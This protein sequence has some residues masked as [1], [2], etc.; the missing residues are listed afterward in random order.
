M[1]R[2]KVI[3]L[4]IV[5]T[6][7]TSSVSMLPVEKEKESSA[8]EATKPSEIIEIKPAP[9]KPTETKP[10]ELI[11]V[12][13]TQPSKPSEPSFSG[14]LGPTTTIVESIPF[15]LAPP[16]RQHHYDQRQEGKYNIRAD[17]ENFVIL[18][19]PSSGNSLLDLLRRSTQRPTHHKRTHHTKHHAHKKYYGNAGKGDDSHL[20]KHAS[21][22]DYLRPEPSDLIDSPVGGEFIEGRTPYHVDISSSEILQPTVEPATSSSRSQKRIE[23]LTRP[24][25][26]DITDSNN[27]YDTVNVGSVASLDGLALAADAKTANNQWELTLLGAQENCGPDRRRDSYGICQF[28]PQDYAT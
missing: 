26:I 13:S 25:L 18:V 15:S 19:V 7:L 22:L 1:W 14:S 3:A 4:L 2:S 17:L 21:R 24:E 27:S 10:S 20:K 9:E 8:T 11:P 23:I 5:C 16:R 6:I 12:D 28:V